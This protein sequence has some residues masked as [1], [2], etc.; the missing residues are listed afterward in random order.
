MQQSTT[1]AYRPFV[2]RATYRTLSFTQ[3]DTAWL[4]RGGAS[5]QEGVVEDEEASATQENKAVNENNEEDEDEEEEED[6]KQ[7]SKKSPASQKAVTVTVQTATG[8]K[9][10]DHSLELNA[11]RSRDI[12]SLKETIR[13][14]L[15]S[16]PP[17]STMELIW[18]GK[19]LPDTTIV[20]DLIEDEDDDEEDDEMDEDNAFGLVLQL[21]MVPPID[22][23]FLP[24]LQ[25]EI[26]HWTTAQLLEAYAANEAALYQ[27]AAS[28]F[29]SRST[30][31][32]DDS[33]EEIEVQPSNDSSLISE[34]IRQQAERIQAQWKT[35]LLTSSKAQNLLADPMAPA[36]QS[37]LMI[38]QTRGER[39]RQVAVAGVKT[40]IK[41]QLQRQFNIDWEA[42]IR[43]FCLFLFFGWFGGRT[44]ASRAILL[45]GAP[46][47]FVLQARQVQLLI[48]QMLYFLLLKPPSIVL[49]LLPAPQQQI[50]VVATK[51]D[52]AM[53]SIYGPDE[54]AGG[55]K[56]AERAR[57]RTSATRIDIPLSKLTP[58]SSLSDDELDDYVESL[59]LE[60]DDDEDE[61]DDDDEDDED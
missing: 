39:V 26:P 31:S 38:T 47:V 46:A 27:N 19:R 61:E 49:S 22:P 18:R 35:E 45:L 1:E 57:I 37:G 54:L 12:A 17:V 25:Q 36:E 34:Q 51:S 30:A 8:F 9:V 40:S 52:K 43:S 21:D 6:A 3:R 2:S 7:A 42:S 50:L 41:L 13:R 44:P 5:M 32:S 55:E 24:Q 23:K 59:I 4:V 29:P 56:V 53:E 28:L 58:S 10:L 20:D 48:K 16:K 11:N 14:Q 60:V 15:P 33:D